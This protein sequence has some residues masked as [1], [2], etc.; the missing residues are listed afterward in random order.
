MKI[1]GLSRSTYY[2]HLKNRHRPKHYNGGRPV[3]GYSVTSNGKPVS[4]EQIKEWIIAIIETDGFSY[5]YKKI[6]ILLKRKYNLIINKKKV[7]RLCKEL[8]ILRPQRKIKRKHP[9]RLARNREITS[10]NQLW[11]LDLKYGFI[12]G[13]NRFFFLASI[14]DVFDRSIINYHIGLTCTAKDAAAAVKGS[15]IRRQLYQSNKKPVLRTD[16]GPQFIADEF[17]TICQQLGLEH[18]RIP[19]KTPNMIAHIEAFHRILEDECMSLYEFQSYAEAYQTVTDYIRYYNETRI[20][21]SLKY[22]S[23]HEFIKNR[24]NIKIPAVKV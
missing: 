14:I 2:Y 20:H 7:Y 6:T 19:C 1:V 10:S 13:E 17:E 11:E 8:E 4:D 16:N 12:A 24:H 21:S 23:P 3:P 18:E 5:G 15:L 9:R 22:M